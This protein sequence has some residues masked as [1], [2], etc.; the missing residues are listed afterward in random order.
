MADVRTVEEK[1]MEFGNDAEKIYSEI[2]N[3]GISNDCRG[4][5]AGEKGCAAQIR[6]GLSS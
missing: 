3:N 6:A 4:L 1:Y 2:N 5:M